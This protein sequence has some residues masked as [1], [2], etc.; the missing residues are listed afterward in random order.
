MQTIKY[1]IIFLLVLSLLGNTKA[2][3]SDGFNNIRCGDDIRKALIGRTIQS[4]QVVDIEARHKDI[5]LDNLGGYIIT[6]DIFLSFWKICGDEYLILEN[7]NVIRDVL[8]FPPHSKEFPRFVGPCCKINNKEVP[9]TI[10]A[11]VVNKKGANY[12]YAIVAWKIDE[13]KVKFVSISAEGLC[14]PRD[15]IAIED[16]AYDK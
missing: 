5:G 14:C 8:K 6:E 12:L 11:R 7:K 9:E 2:H 1:L 10:I 13:K 15:G 4:E 16:G 3:S